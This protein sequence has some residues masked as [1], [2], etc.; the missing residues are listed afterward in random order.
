MAQPTPAPPAVDQA[1]AEK[2][3][4]EQYQQYALQ[5]QAWAAA[6]PGYQPPPPGTTPPGAPADYSAYY[7][8]YQ[9]Q[10]PP[11]PGTAAPEAQ[12]QLTPEEQY[13]QQYAA[14]YAQYGYPVSSAHAP[15]AAAPAYADYYSYPH[16]ST[17]AP[18]YSYP[19]FPPAAAPV[20]AA[21]PQQQQQPQYQQ[22]AGSAPLLTHYPSYSH[23]QAQSHPSS[24]YSS[25]ASAPT[26][27]TYTNGN[28]SNNAPY[29]QASRTPQPP[30]ANQNYYGRNS[31]PQPAPQRKPAFDYQAFQRQKHQEAEQQKASRLSEE[32][33]Q[34]QQKLQEIH[35]EENEMK[36]KN[37]KP[38]YLSVK[39]KKAKPLTTNVLESKAPVETSTPAGSGW[40]QSL[41]DYVQRVFETIA[42][43]DRDDAQNELKALVSKLHAQGRL[44]ETD[45]DLM[46]IPSKYKRKKRGHVNSSPEPPTMGEE[47]RRR[48]E[49]RM[50]RFEDQLV[51][52]PV[53]K[54]PVAPVQEPVYNSDVIDWDMHTIVG[55][56]TKLEKNYL[57]LT[58]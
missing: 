20:S 53:V 37:E 3:Y 45:W 8:H 46:P 1:T 40:P 24:S 54:K 12:Q 44:W 49:K 18:A 27:G 9:Q 57:R 16:N 52:K 7:A 6:N 21:P 55:T 13:A 14:Y 32:P 26:G 23:P 29:N 42:D 39:S 25:A 34:I 17:A 48:R 43:A 11:P 50:R 51:E 41:K 30:P 15:G 36:S 10:Q 5:Y 28:N 58:S 31:A 33:R 22:Q 35:L 38:A 4:A 2:L 47:E 19:G 56:C